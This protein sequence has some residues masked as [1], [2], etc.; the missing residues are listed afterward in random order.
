MLLHVLLGCSTLVPVVGLS[1][2]AKLPMFAPAVGGQSRLVLPKSALVPWT[3]H[4][5]PLRSP[6]LQVPV[7]LKP[8]P[9]QVGQ[10]WST[11]RP[12]KTDEVSAAVDAPLPVSGFAVP[13]IVPF[14]MFVTHT[15]T[16]PEERGSGA[17]KMKAQVPPEQSPLAEQVFEVSF[18]QRWL[19][20]TVVLAIGPLTV[21]EPH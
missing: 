4:A 19:F 3:V 14:T 2:M 1:A 10:G 8:E 13:V 5:W 11:V 9:L 21:Q 6:P 12:V 17:P 15:G 7:W 16:P 20:T 18:V